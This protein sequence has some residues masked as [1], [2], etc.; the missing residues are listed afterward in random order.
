[1]VDPHELVKIN[2]D[3]KLNIEEVTSWAVLDSLESIIAVLNDD[4][5]IIATNVAWRDFA[6]L[7][8]VAPGFDWIGVNYL[9]VCDNAGKAGV[10]GARSAAD[11]VRA[12]LKGDSKG[13]QQVYPC[14]SPSEKRWYTMRVSRLTRLGAGRALVCHEDVSVIM[15]A[16]EELMKA[17]KRAEATAQAVARR[18]DFIRAITDAL[19]AMVG[20]W[21][22]DL[23]CRFA[24]KPY[25]EWFGK[26]PEA[27][28]GISMRD[29]LGESLFTLNE[30]YIRGAL[31]GERQ[32]FERTLTK[33]DGQI[34][35]TLVNYIP[36]ID[37]HGSVLGFFVLVNDV[38]PLKMAEARGRN[39][40][41][42]LRAVFANVMDGIIVIDRQGMIMTANPA[43]ERLFGYDMDT[44]IGSNVQTLMPEP[45]RSAHDGHLARYQ[46]GR[47]TRVIGRGRE[48]NGLTRGGRLF[49]AELTVTEVTV[50]DQQAFIGVIRDITER[51]LAQE[52]LTRLA[53]T[54]SLTKLA[55]R[56]LFDE[57]LAA[58][59]TRHLRSGDDLSLILIDVDHFKLFNDA[60]GHVAGDDCLR[61]VAGA[62][63]TA[64]T[65]ATDLA[66]RYGGEEFACILPMTGQAGALKVAEEIRIAVSRLDIPH[67]LSNAAPHVTASLGVVTVGPGFSG[68]ESRL[69]TLADEQLYAA[70]SQGRNRVCESGTC[71]PS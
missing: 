35:H 39:A 55:N 52:H 27:I 43:A 58:E 69:V 49:P 31:A 18:E 20:Y 71:Q 42:S 38:T 59:W 60:Y 1:M 61:R 51:K 41:A 34:G 53:T 70:K 10:G 23:I 11:G 3:L 46:S 6:R 21:D 24:N 68:P 66:A 64:I 28:I 7:N 8:G 62:V 13:Y 22:G 37:A 56:R 54:D 63:S 9:A 32:Q 19:P 57:V 29:L 4:G 12:V 5:V 14:H 36:D 50:N 33:A 15:R 17:R 67:R 26:S 25:L 48:I 30:C 45:D 65:R 44:L 47:E 2:L 16:D 40:E